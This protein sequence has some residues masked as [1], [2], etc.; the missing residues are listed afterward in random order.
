MKKPIPKRKVTTT[1]RAAARTAKPVTRA[2]QADLANSIHPR[3]RAAWRAWLA[4]NESRTNGVWLISFKK[5][6]GKQVMTYAESVEEA[7]CFGWIDSKPRSLDS[8]RS[9]LWFAPRKPGSAWSALN[10]ARVT[11]LI[12]ARRMSAAGLARITAAKKDGSWAALD[13]VEALVIPP[14]LAREFD[15]RIPARTNFDAFPRSVKKGILEWIRGAK[16]PETRAKRV[17]ETATLAAKNVRANQWR[18]S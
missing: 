12:A 13:D 2:T 11:K 1:K 4:A 9:M 3:D 5:D 6:S 7:L 18:P 8:E 15:A 16:K 10:K 17:L 14:D